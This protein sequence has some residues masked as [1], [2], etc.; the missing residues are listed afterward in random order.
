MPGVQRIASEI[1]DRLPPQDADA[2]RAVI[3]SAILLPETLDEVGRFL[4][5]DDFYSDAH[6]RLFAHMSAMREKGMVIDAV[7]LAVRLREAGELEAI[8]GKA[9]IAELA[10]SPP[11]ASYATHYARVVLAHSRRRKIIHAGVEAIRDAWDLSID[12]EEIINR[13]ESTLAGIETSE[14]FGDPKPVS[15]LVPASLARMEE[16]IRRRSAAGVLTGLYEFDENTGGLFPGELVILAARPSIG[17]TSLAC[18]VAYHVASVRGH[19]YMASLEMDNLELTEKIICTL[20]RVSSKRVRTGH[21]G[22]NDYEAL[23]AGGAE[24]SNAQL[25]FHDRAGMTVADIRRACRRML[26]KGLHLVIV[27]YLQLIGPADRKQKRY[28]QVGQIVRDLKALARELKAPLLC[29]CQLNRDTEKDGKR[30]RLHNLRESGEIEQT[31]DVVMFLHRGEPHKDKDGKWIYPT[32]TEL[33][34]EKNR[35]GQKGTIELEWDAPRTRFISK[36]PLPVQDR[37]NYEPAFDQFG[38]GNE[39]RF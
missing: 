25:I 7:T 11:T 24:L 12:P 33:I 36:E 23:A 30:P 26:R 32:T 4:G 13:T 6:R 37:D 28:E 16:T 3:G 34:T 9:Y 2:E 27:D 20:S 19:V 8:G 22:S 17:K 38:S 21:I 31:A 35:K 10:F 18:Q 29:L 1:L 14:S 39:E 5:P 15:E